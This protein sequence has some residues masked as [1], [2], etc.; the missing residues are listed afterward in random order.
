MENLTFQQLK[1][2]V[3]IIDVASSL[4]YALDKSKGLKQPSFVLSQDGGEVDRIY[5]KNPYNPE[6]QGFWRRE[7]NKGDVI[8]FVRE[9][10]DRFGVVGYNDWDM[11]NK[12]LHSFA[13]HDYTAPRTEYKQLYTPPVFDPNRWV[14]VSNTYYRDRILE[15]RGIDRYSSTIFA[16]HIHIIKD[17]NA[18][19][20]YVN[21]GFPY[22]KPGETEVIGYEIRGIGHFKS[23]AAGTDSTHGM[24]IADFTQ[25]P[26]QAKNLYIAESALDAI[27]YYQLHK[28]QIELFSSVFVSFG[29]AF[30]DE[31]FKSLISHY[32]TA[33]RNLLF[34]NDLYGRIYDIR[35]Y[36]LAT[37]KQLEVGVDKQNDQIKLSIDGTQLSLSPEQTSLSEV[38]RQTGN[39]LSPDIITVI[40]PEGQV[41]D[42]NDILQLEASTPSKLSV[43][44]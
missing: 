18:E 40:K 8:S 28:Q 11:I 37:E 9:N 42:W 29:G 22:R 13:N 25:S 3:S 7:G 15:G 32:D 24:W 21:I 41:K 36:A 34:D 4:G 20:S 14:K 19:K 35:A 39:R 16:D 17:A 10:L 5:I 44:R 43:H 27:A 26:L 12:I 6:I 33:R 1:A 23:K 30:S 38:L 2:R 31:Q